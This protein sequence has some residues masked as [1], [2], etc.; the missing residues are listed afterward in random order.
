M[1]DRFLR[2]VEHREGEEEG[3]FH[4]SFLNSHL[5]LGFNFEVQHE[6]GC[7]AVPVLHFGV[8]TENQREMRI[9]K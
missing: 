9:E 1:A 5:S 8:P 4:I 3:I 2:G 6:D 7:E